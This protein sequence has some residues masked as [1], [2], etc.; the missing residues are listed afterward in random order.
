MRR[1]GEI[2]LISSVLSDLPIPTVLLLG[3]LPS[4]FGLQSPADERSGKSIGI[5][6]WATTAL[7]WGVLGLVA[8]DF[9]KRAG[10]QRL[11]YMIVAAIGLAFN[12]SVFSAPLLYSGAR[13]STAVD[14]EAL[15]CLLLTP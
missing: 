10:T 7:G 6:L 14:L 2:L 4:I 1:I 11:R 8:A 9:I 5:V 12:Y 3:A 13:E 15:G